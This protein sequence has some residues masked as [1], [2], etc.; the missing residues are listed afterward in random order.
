TLEALLNDPDFSAWANNH[1]GGVS[2]EDKAVVLAWNHVHDL[3]TIYDWKSGKLTARKEKVQLSDGKLQVEAPSGRN[4]LMFVTDTNPL[5]YGA[6]A[7]VITTTD[8]EEIATLKKLAGLLGSAV[9]AFI[10]TREG[11]FLSKET[12]ECKLDGTLDQRLIC[13]RDSVEDVQQLAES[14]EMQHARA[15]SYIQVVELRVKP[16]DDLAK[17]FTD[18]KEKIGTLDKAIR[19][20]TLARFAVSE[21]KPCSKV[22]DAARAAIAFF[23]S[24]SDAVKRETKLDALGRTIVGCPKQDSDNWSETVRK[25]K[26]DSDKS[27]FKELVDVSD[28][29]TT[30]DELLAKRQALFKTAAWLTD[31]E[32]TARRYGGAKYDPS[33]FINGVVAVRGGSI[34]AVLDKRNSGGFKLEA[35]LPATDFLPVRTTPIEKKVDV[36]STT[37]WGLGAGVI[38]T[39]LE[40]KSWKAV[41]DPNNPAQKVIGKPSR[42]TRA[43]QIALLA[44][45]H[46]G[47]ATIGR[48]VRYGLQFGAGTDTSKPS[49]FLGGS[50]DLGRWFRIGG[51]RTWQRVPALVEGETELVT[52]VTDTV[53]TRE[54]FRS[55]YYIALSISLDGIPLF[56]TP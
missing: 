51:G 10:Q 12:I 1:L 38:Y 35:S 24:E 19:D 50:V 17:V 32:A 18:S 22:V 29:V 40:E 31:L 26:E 14:I 36:T 21:L 9:V 20:L 23:A 48:Y 47:W 27:P 34:E 43:G 49:F 4:A 56:N 55:K 2:L 41:P 3:W 39:P 37:K 46:P 42:S 54:T 33:C 44:N 7:M 28:L 25:Y 11:R 30:A 13:L 6:N 15:V 53:P 52:P 8:T 5:V 16:A 45:L